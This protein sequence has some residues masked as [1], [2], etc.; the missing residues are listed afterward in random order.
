MHAH[1]P[2]AGGLS[3][4]R[5]GDQLSPDPKPSLGLRRLVDDRAGV[6]DHLPLQPDTPFLRREGIKSGLSR[7]HLDSRTYTSSFRGVLIPNSRPIGVEERCRAARLVV[8][9]RSLFSHRAGLGVRRPSSPTRSEAMGVRHRSRRPLPGVG[10]APDQGDERDAVPAPPTVGVPG[11]QRSPVP[12]LARSMTRRRPGPY[13]NTPDSAVG[14]HRT[15]CSRTPSALSANEGGPPVI[16]S[17]D[18]ADDAANF[19]AAGVD[20]DQPTVG[21]PHHDGCA[22]DVDVLATDQRGRAGRP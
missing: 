6:T 22:E 13:S 12:R 14:V 19:L 2:L 5:T 10:L 18:S 11:R 9:S 1:G 4:G 8:P 20:Q 21:D 15:G 7:R 3:T 16:E 17:L